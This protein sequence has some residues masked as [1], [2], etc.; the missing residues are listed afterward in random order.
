M[1]D[2]DEDPALGG[3][4]A[5]ARPALDRI[6]VEVLRASAAAVLFGTSSRPRIARYE[7]LREVGTGGGGSVFVARDPELAREIAIKLIPAS[8]PVLRARAVAEGQ[9][10][11]RLAHPNVVAVFDVGVVEDRV[12]LAMELVRGESLRALARRA[13]RRDLIRAYRQACDGLV[14]AHAA[15]LIHRDFKPDNA[16]VGADGRVRIVDF[17]LAGDG[18]SAV[19]AGTP[20]YMAP[21]QRAHAPATAAVDQYAFAIA[22]REALGDPLP[23][24]LVPIL[25]RASSAEPAARFPSMTALARALADDPPARWRRRALIGL[26]IIAVALAA[27]AFGVGRAQQASGPTCDAVAALAPAWTPASAVGNCLVPLPAPGAPN[28]MRRMLFP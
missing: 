17:G 21:E 12:Y 26:P 3:Q 19:R 23:R 20:G 27:G 1:V 8:D 7:L 6:R 13:T 16:V 10:L 24:W 5:A 15:G 25:R 9:A 18:E 11:A 22:L 28:R 14:A 4:I 2:L